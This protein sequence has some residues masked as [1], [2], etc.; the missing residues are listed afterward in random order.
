M[1]YK[2]IINCHKLTSNVLN[3]IYIGIII[4]FFFFF[5]FFRFPYDLKS[6]MENNLLN[7]P[8]K[9]QFE[10]N[11]EGGKCKMSKKFYKGKLSN[12]K[13]HLLRKHKEKADGIELVEATP[14][15]RHRNDDEIQLIKRI[16]LEVD[17]N[18]LIRE[19]IRLMV[20]SNLSLA[21]ADE[22]GQ[23]SD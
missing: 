6:K 17:V 15:T 16:K 2:C 8:V 19:R 4:F 22:I 14:A 21:S 20:R 23:M 12:L 13:D 7:E 10:I 18:Q 11:K 3:E 5:F 1:H 9:S